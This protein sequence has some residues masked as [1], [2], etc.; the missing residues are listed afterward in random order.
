MLRADGYK[1]V[2]TLV[3]D[4]VPDRN[5]L[6]AMNDIETKKRERDAAQ[7]AAEAKK[8]MVVMAAEAEKEARKLNGEGI[9]D[10]RKAIVEGL[11]ESVC[12]FVRSASPLVALK[13]PA[14]GSAPRRSL[15]PG[16]GGRR[17]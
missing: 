12:Q 13:L 6:R 5:V 3:T 1:I 15:P 17:L 11:K 8:V 2:N 14:G 7:Q 16:A 9:A 4:L 10:Q